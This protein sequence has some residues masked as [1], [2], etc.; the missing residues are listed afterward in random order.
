MAVSIPVSPVPAAISVAN[1]PVSAV[2]NSAE[3][4]TAPPAFKDD[5]ELQAHVRK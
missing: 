5:S 4:G 1:V 2:E 3:P